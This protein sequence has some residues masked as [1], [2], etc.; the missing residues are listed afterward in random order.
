MTD[1][2]KVLDEIDLHYQGERIRFFFE[3]GGSRLIPTVIKERGVFY[4]NE[5]LEFIRSSI[6]QP[7]IFLDIGANI[8]NHTLFFS[9]I[10]RRR[11]MAFEAIPENFE[12][13]KKNIEMNPASE[14]VEAFNFGLGSSNSYADFEQPNLAEAGSFRRK[15]GSVAGK[16][17]IRRLDDVLRDADLKL[18]IAFMKIDVEGMELEVLQGAVEALKDHRPGLSIEIKTNKEYLQI[19]EFLEPFDYVPIGAF[20][21]T[22]TFV[23]RSITVPS[24][25]RHLQGLIRNFAALY[26]KVRGRS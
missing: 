17:E 8:G 10:A 9:R 26:I 15:K 22:P 1:I 20:N 11:V 23:F 24:E 14:P 3:K 16:I 25:L 2:F 12:V 7:G 4:E 19:C 18:P 13:L 5:C 21:A 6:T